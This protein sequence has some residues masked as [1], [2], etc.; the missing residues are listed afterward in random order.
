MRIQTR[1][2]Q[3]INVSL[4]ALGHCVWHPDVGHNLDIY[5]IRLT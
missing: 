3:S 1:D 5:E 2:Q 4:S